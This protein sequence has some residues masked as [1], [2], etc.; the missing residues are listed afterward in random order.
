MKKLDLDPRDYRVV[1]S[2]EREPLFLLRNL[3]YFLL[4]V[5]IIVFVAYVMAPEPHDLNTGLPFP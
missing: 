4:F 1:K 3:P 5:A 2:G